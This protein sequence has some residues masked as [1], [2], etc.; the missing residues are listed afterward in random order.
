VREAIEAAAPGGGFTLRTTGGT[1]GTGAVRNAEQLDRS[2]INLEAYMHA[3]L[4]YGRY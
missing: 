1:G 2:I 3:A 4:K